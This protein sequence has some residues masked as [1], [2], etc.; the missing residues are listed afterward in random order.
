[1]AILVITRWSSQ[2]VLRFLF[3]ISPEIPSADLTEGHL[4]DATEGEMRAMMGYKPS[5]SHR[6]QAVGARCSG[7]IL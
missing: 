7:M 1:M 2:K 3:R 6:H 4:F 5:L